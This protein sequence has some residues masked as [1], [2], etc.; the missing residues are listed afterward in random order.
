MSVKV[1]DDIK[2]VYEHILNEFNDDL[3]LKRYLC[4]TFFADIMRRKDSGNLY[5]V[6][7]ELAHMY[8][9]S[10]VIDGIIY[11]SVKVEGEP[12]VVLN[13]NAVDKS[14]KHERT[15]LYEIVEDYGYAV[16]NT[17]K[18][19]SGTIDTSGKINWGKE[20]E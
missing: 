16:Y 1:W 11:T 9:E 20:D 2:L 7:S 15:E 14:I 6:T 5:N 8:G 18:L 10:G 13:T 3:F 17:K 4:D 19:Y 12:V